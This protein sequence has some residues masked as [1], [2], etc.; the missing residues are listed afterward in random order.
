MSIGFTV[1]AG[2]AMHQDDGE[3]NTDEDDS[4]MVG[5]AIDSSRD[6]D[7][8][9]TQDNDLQSS[10]QEDCIAPLESADLELES[11]TDCSSAPTAQTQ[12]E[13][14]QKINTG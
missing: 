11:E 9:D 13:L 8:A 10:N 14:S 5:T 3:W 12:V 2:L 7:S 6:L 1:L 4:F